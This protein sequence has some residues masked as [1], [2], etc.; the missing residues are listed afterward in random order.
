MIFY[1]VSS[2]DTPLIRCMNPFSFVFYFLCW[3]DFEPLG[4][5][6]RT[7]ITQKPTLRDGKI[8]CT[9]TRDETFLYL[10]TILKFYNALLL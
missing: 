10:K 6:E 7:L 4:C 2:K 8:D 5:L 9:R 1:H 3:R